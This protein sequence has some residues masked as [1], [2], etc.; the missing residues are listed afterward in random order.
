[1]AASATVDH[2][3]NRPTWIVA[4]DEPRGLRCAEVNW[5]VERDVFIRFSRP[6]LISADRV[7]VYAY[8]KDCISFGHNIVVLEKSGT[9]CKIVMSYQIAGAGE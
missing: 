2:L 3:P 8:I 4:E 6:A 7:L 9:S 5:E 1:M